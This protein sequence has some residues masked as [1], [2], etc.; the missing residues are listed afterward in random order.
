VI[1]LLKTGS[2]QTLKYAAI[3]I[4]LAGL[5]NVVLI[6]LI[7]IAAEQTSLME[8]VSTKSRIL[9]LIGFAIF[10]LSIRSSLFV[11]NHFL[12]QRLGELRLRIMN[13]IRL[14]Q[15]RALESLNQSQIYS[16][17]AKEGDYLSQNFPMLVSAIQS[18]ISL[19]FCLL[20]IAYLSVPAFLVIAS[21]TVF[22]LFYFWSSRQSLNLALLDVNQHEQ[23]LF[24]SIGHFLKGHKEIRL[25]RVKSNALYQQ[26]L[27]IG[28]QLEASIVKV[29]GQWVS[30]LMFTNAF[31]YVLLG[32]VVF[33]L[34]FFLQGFSDVIYKIAA[35]AIFSVGP[36]TTITIT[37]PILSRANAE[38]DEIYNLE[39]K[40]DSNNTFKQSN[41]NTVEPL[42][43]NFEKIALHNVTFSY[44]N[45]AGEVTFASGPFNM[46]INRGDIIFIR[47]GNGSGKSTL[48][49]LVSGLYLPEEGIIEVDDIVISDINAQSY[50]EIYSCIF[51]DFHLFD[52]LD[53]IDKVSA[54][55]FSELVELMELTG[56]V[57][58]EN[59]RFST[60]KL[61]HGQRKR[62]AMI[63]SLLVDKDIYIFDEWAADQDAHFRKVFYHQILPELKSRNKTI[64]AVTHDEQYWHL[65]DTLYTLDLGVLS[66]DPGNPT[67]I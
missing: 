12:Q 50:R 43:K 29:G 48:M 9:F 25:N 33:V 51:T 23:S 24:E 38:L 7:N 3:V 44:R 20:Y 30:L 65:C 1:G 26:F 46:Q 67:P 54:N 59:N 11:A 34:P 32:I 42:F 27:E 8:P 37:L 45:A 60:L 61:S 21:I 6:A 41:S 14:S 2:S 18:V 40:L 19:I 36:F 58:L 49:K 39:K 56:K 28:D 5:S 55:R 13:K 15:L 17:L 63:A 57:N 4:C 31:L 16:A 22:A 66:V 10:F 35:T 52:N 64:I 62:L 47:G 53:G